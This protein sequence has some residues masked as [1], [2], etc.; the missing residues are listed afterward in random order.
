MV[1][2]MYWAVRGEE[3]R[4]DQVTSSGSVLLCWMNCQSIDAISI[5]LFKQKWL[6]KPMD[7]A[8]VILKDV[9]SFW[10]GGWRCRRRS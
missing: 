7:T 3:L 1:V 9:S 10:S 4:L 6:K 5:N 8:S 2:A